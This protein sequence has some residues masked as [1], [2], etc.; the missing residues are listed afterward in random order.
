MTKYPTLLAFFAPAAA[1]WVAA[2][3][4]TDSASSGK[5]REGTAEAQTQ[6]AGV[7]PNQFRC[8]SIAS[9][10]TLGQVL[11]GQIKQTDNPTAMPKGVASPCMYEVVHD[12]NV[13]QWQFDFDCRDN[14]K[15]TFD[16]LVEQ[17][18]QQNLDM[19]ADWNHKSDAGMFKPN[20]AGIEYNRPGDPVE[21]SVGS[22][23]LDHHGQAVIFL[24]DDAPCY[25]RVAGKDT[26]RR[27]VLAKLIA[28]NLTFQNAPMS[29]RMP[30][31]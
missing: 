23:A 3:C 16:K 30:T 17:Y 1:V 22:K 18:R 14:Y 15:T 10:E 31:K 6:L 29:P 20:D 13:E 25:V 24:D 5:P 4:K 2:G 7:W 11:G 27:Q 21:I 28:K 9:A 19:I 8:D 26:A 12:G